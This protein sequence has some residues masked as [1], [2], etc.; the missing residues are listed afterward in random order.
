MEDFREDKKEVDT[1]AL[2]ESLAENVRVMEARLG[3]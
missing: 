2:M 1:A 3:A